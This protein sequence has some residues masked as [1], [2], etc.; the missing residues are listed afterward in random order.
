MGLAKN[1]N[2]YP[3]NHKASCTVN[4]THPD[5]PSPPTSRSSKSKLCSSPSGMGV[6]VPR[7]KYFPI[8]VRDECTDRSF[9][10]KEH[11]LQGGAGG[12]AVKSV[13]MVLLS[14]ALSVRWA[15]GPI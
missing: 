10:A 8:G 12:L 15:D 6:L 14:C 1:L 7:S 4:S 5:L 13:D 11:V 2:P 3:W 9:S